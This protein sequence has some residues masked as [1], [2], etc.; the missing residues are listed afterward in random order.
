[1]HVQSLDMAL[2]TVGRNTS[3]RATATV[4]DAKDNPVEGAT[5]L[6][7]GRSFETNLRQN[8]PYTGEGPPVIA[9]LG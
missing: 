5:V 7:L 2:K 9:I 8:G 4:V 1:M 6:Y 3:A